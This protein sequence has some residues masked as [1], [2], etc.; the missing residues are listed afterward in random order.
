MLDFIKSVRWIIKKNWY[1][2]ILELIFGI[3]LAIISLFPTIV[4]GRLVDAIKGDETVIVFDLSKEEKKNYEVYSDTIVAGDNVIY[5]ITFVNDSNN[6]SIVD[7]NLYLK[8]NTKFSFKTSGKTTFKI[9]SENSLVSIKLNGEE[10]TSN[11]NGVYSLTKGTV[12]GI[13]LSDIEIE[14]INITIITLTEHFVI[15][16]ILI[17]FLL[18]I[19]AIYI[20]AL[21]K[22]T[23]QNF[24]TTRIYYML[25]DRYMQSIFV[26]D[27]SFFEKFQSGDLLARALGD[28]KTVKFSAGNRLLNILFEI[29]TVIVAF[30]Y[31]IYINPILAVCCFVPLTLILVCN[32]LLKRIVKENYKRV[33]EK[34]SELSNVILESIT[35]VRTVRA[36][37]KEEDSYN[38][39]LKYSKEAYKI[40]VKNIKINVVFEP[41]FQFIVSIST[42]ICFALGG[43]FYYKG[44]ITVAGLAKF[45][46]VLGLFQAPLK[47]IGNMINNFYQS[48]ISADR[49]NEI[50]D[51]KTNIKSGEDNLENIDTIE[52]K[53]FVF[54]YPNDSFDTI[55]GINF[56][57]NKGETV[58]IVGRTG[59]G[60]STIAKQLLRQYET[61]D[62]EIFINNKP[63]E[64]YNKEEIRR[65]ISYVP[66][67]HVLFSRSVFDNVLLGK[68]D[69]SMAE[70]NEAIDLADFRKDI[71]NLSDGLDTIVGEYGVTLSGGQKQRLG[72]ARAFLKNSDVLILDDS[73]SAVD[74][75]TEANIIS[76]LKKFRNDKTNIIICHRLSQVKDADKILVLNNGEIVETGNH[77]TLMEKRGWYY[78]Q[79]L[80]QQI[81]EVD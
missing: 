43:Y 10:I 4:L 63:I 76:N 46:M 30:I 22:R 58:G 32:I 11:S 52:F 17:P 79:Y 39:N 40:E 74:G 9:G 47:K 16:E 36:Y 49:L 68:R 75:K 77:K 53:N 61:E 81:K 31:M 34:N 21:I 66:Q 13:A 27:A 72:I 64:E 23:I 71:E 26:Q 7:N 80:S 41:L 59:S 78:R 51:S 37:S 50:Y 44:N 65:R 19:F 20:V 67:E 60:K 55:K 48:L 62:N 73:L 1:K 56:V 35:N 28:I 5:D 29:L 6:I 8:E 69:A 57:I 14:Y 18:I 38:K 54:A 12:E 25:N 70:I 3:T 24:L 42:F 15:Y 2:Y 33:R 45:Y